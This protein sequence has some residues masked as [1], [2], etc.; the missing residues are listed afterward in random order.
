MFALK[1][2][3]ILHAANKYTSG[4]IELQRHYQK[5]QKGNHQKKTF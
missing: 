2:E 1:V 4:A 5:V 3:Q